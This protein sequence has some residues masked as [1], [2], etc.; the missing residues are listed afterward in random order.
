MLNK[1]KQRELAYVVKIDN[2]VPI[3]GADKVECAFV[4]GWS[5][6]VHKGEF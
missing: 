3:E 2:I 4:N 1:D 5:V 6:M